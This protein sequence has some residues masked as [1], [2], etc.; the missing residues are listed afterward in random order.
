MVVVVLLLVQEFHD[1]QVI[2]NNLDMKMAQ[3]NKE[4]AMLGTTLASLESTVDEKDCA[5]T[6]DM[7]CLDLKGKKI[8]STELGQYEYLV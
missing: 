1:L 8:I 5:F 7:Q 2:C 4:I 6:L 3:V